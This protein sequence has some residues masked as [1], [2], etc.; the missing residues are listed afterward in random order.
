MRLLWSFLSLSSPPSWST[1]LSRLPFSAS[2]KC[3][4][5]ERYHNLLV[6][7]FVLTTGT[8]EMN[9][10]VSSCVTTSKL[11]IEKSGF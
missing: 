3:Q 4:V 11:E 6:G 7:F 9:C 8:A 2:T 10:S 5:P 1:L